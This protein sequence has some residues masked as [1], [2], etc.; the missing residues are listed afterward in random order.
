MDDFILNF[1]KEI[2]T[3]SNSRL[4]MFGPRILSINQDKLPANINVFEG[5]D[6]FKLRFLSPKVFA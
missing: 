6:E 4:S 5:L 2:L 1:K 3:I